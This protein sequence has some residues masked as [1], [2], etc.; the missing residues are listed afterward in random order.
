[1]IFFS[2]LILK[3]NDNICCNAISMYTD[4]LYYRGTAS[5]ISKEMAVPKLNFKFNRYMS[6]GYDMTENIWSVFFYIYIYKLTHSH[7][8]FIFFNGKT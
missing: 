7:F 1:M 5:V 6:S 4:K 8:S 2:V 3:L